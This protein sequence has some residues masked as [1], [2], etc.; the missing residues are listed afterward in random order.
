MSKSAGNVVLLNDV[1][2]KG[3][4]PLALRLC[5]LEN[6]YRS[7]MDLTWDSLKAADTT[8]ERWRGKYSNWKVQG[9]IDERFV[10]D[11]AQGSLADIQN[12][13]DTPRALQQLRKLEKDE[14]I[15]GATKAACFE[16]M[17]QIYGLDFLKGQAPKAELTSELTDLL[18]ARRIA[19][20][21]KDFAKSDELRDQMA[22]LGIL[23]KDTPDGQEWDW[24]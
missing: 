21:A 7:Q 6:R 4:D 10:T 20:L 19:R 18:D 24:N 15:S 9:D 1:I 16:T 3:L 14:L 17:D 22:K 5:F 23:V 8:L 11:F 2:A 13:L 12:D